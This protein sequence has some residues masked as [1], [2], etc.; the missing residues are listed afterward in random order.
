MNGNVDS[1]NSEALLKKFQSMLH[2]M[3]KDASPPIFIVAEG[4]SLAP[5][6][7]FS[8]PIDGEFAGRAFGGA[9]PSA[10]SL[11]Q[12][13]GSGGQDLDSPAQPTHTGTMVQLPPQP[14]RNS[15]SNA[16]G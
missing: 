8:V 11:Q 1:K 7:H 6:A 4:E 3:K 13:L 9:K 14:S 5:N 2:D 16:I 12:Q 15:A 10:D